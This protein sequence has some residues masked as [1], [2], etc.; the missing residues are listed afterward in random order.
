MSAAGYGKRS[1]LIV[2]EQEPLNAETPRAAL[3]A[4]PLTATDAFYVRDHGPVPEI[5]PAAWRLHIHGLVERELDLE[6]LR[7]VATGG[8]REVRPLVQQYELA[9]GRRLNLL[10]HGRVVGYKFPNQTSWRYTSPGKLASSVAIVNGVVY[11][12][13]ETGMLTAFL[14]PGSQVP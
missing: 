2:H 12:T 11:L 4:G 6:E 3:A 10:A 13:S 5:D 8:T 1:D 7:S 14:V 9:D